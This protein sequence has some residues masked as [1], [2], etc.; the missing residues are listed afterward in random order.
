M[1]PAQVDSGPSAGS[2]LR[3]LRLPLERHVTGAPVPA[4]GLVHA[5]RTPD[6]GFAMARLARPSSSHRPVRAWGPGEHG[7]VA[8]WAAEQ[9]AQLRRCN[10][11]AGGGP[12]SGASRLLDAAD[13]AA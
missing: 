11:L 5:A 8:S 10:C 13:G 6:P 9:V 2:A 3:P 1:A 12:Q 4:P 7:D